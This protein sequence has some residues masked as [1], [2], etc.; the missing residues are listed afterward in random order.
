MA[1]VQMLLFIA[2][3]GA[4]G[5]LSVRSPFQARISTSLCSEA[6]TFHHAETKSENSIEE[7]MS[8]QMPSSDSSVRKRLGKSSFLYR[9][10][11][12]GPNINVTSGKDLRRTAEQH[13]GKIIG[14]SQYKKAWTRWL[15][16]AVEAIREDL[17]KQL[18]QQ[19]ESERDE[20]G[21]D[22]KEAFEKLFF[23]LGV[24]ADEGTMPSFENEAARKGYALEFFCRGRALAEF[25]LET[26]STSAED[27]LDGGCNMAIYPRFW[28]QALR[29]PD[30]P[31]LGTGTNQSPTAPEQTTYEIVSLGGGP[32]FD[33]VGVALA[34]AFS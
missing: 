22:L 34:A 12:G 28:N 13:S 9:H 2:A 24:A 15:Y 14:S 11:T 5:L 18:L 25:L 16:L 17:G 33:F 32:G 19:T 6:S 7:I 26:P 23:D 8:P 31:L 30:C 3:P 10:L 29:S 1:L 27:A 4:R 21:E 20:N